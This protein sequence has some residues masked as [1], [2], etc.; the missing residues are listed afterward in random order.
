MALSQQQLDKAKKA[1]E[2]LSSLPTDPL[3]RSRS[4]NPTLNAGRTTAVTPD[5]QARSDAIKSEKGGEIKIKLLSSTLEEN[6]TIAKLIM[7]T[8]I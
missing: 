2:Y 8:C 4:G 3:E 5:P 7:F 1:I 6:S